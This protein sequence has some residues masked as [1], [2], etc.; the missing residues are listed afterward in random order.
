LMNRNNCQVNKEAP[1]QYCETN[2]N[3][4]YMRYKK[5]CGRYIT[6]LL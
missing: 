2:K 1:L 4:N 5:K 6:K 3:K